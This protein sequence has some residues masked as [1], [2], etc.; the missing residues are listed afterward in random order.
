LSPP[1]AIDT[2]GRVDRAWSDVGGFSY[3]WGAA[4]PAARRAPYE[5]VERERALEDMIVVELRR[6]MATHYADGQPSQVRTVYAAFIDKSGLLR[7]ASVANGTMTFTAGV[8]PATGAKSSG[9]ATSSRACRAALDQLIGDTG[10]QLSH[11]ERSRV[12]QRSSESA[13]I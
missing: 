2:A 6:G 12:C 8:T 3:S 9:S 7:L 10:W 4:R 11:G 5:Q 1:F 13:E